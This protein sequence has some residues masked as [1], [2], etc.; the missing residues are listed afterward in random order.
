MHIANT[1]TNDWENRTGNAMF[2]GEVHAHGLVDDKMSE[3]TRLLL[4]KFSPGGRTRWH[5]HSFEQALVIVDGRGIVASETQGERIVQSGDV[6]VFNT[7]EKHWHGAT[8]TTG[9]SHIA[10]NLAGSNQILE[11]SEI[12]TPNV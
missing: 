5:T 1:N 10:V 3:Q 7:N 8:N 6:V 4:V 2:M 9:M 11:D 12:K